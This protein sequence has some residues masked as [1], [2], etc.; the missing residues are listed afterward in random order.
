MTSVLIV[1]DHPAFAESLTRL[2]RGRASYQVE[3]AAT[4]E[5][6]LEKLQDLDVD[7]A[8]VDVSL[9]GRSGIWLVSAL[10][11]MKPHLPCLVL[12]GRA[13]R[14]YVEQAMEAGAR[15]YVLKEDV[16]GVLEAVRQVLTGGTYISA[17]LRPE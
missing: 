11:E 17:A 15:G 2:L 10:H 7:L 5:D 6:A 16:P 4:G 12:S 3:R 1:E 14:I 9:P 8:I 13:N